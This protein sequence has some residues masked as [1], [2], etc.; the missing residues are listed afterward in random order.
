MLYR[1][2][3]TTISCSV[4]VSLADR[5]GKIAAHR[6]L[7]LSA[8][9]CRVLMLGLHQPDPAHPPDPPDPSR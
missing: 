7:T 1:E 4:P 8:V 3:T 5:L 2:A 6:G 9:T